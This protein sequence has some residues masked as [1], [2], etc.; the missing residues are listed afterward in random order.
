MSLGSTNKIISSYH[1]RWST[2]KARIVR[3]EQRGGAAGGRGNGTIGSRLAGEVVKQLVHNMIRE[4]FNGGG[5]GERF[6]DRNPFQ[7]FLKGII[8]SNSIGN[9]KTKFPTHL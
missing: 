5:W 8:P 6:G 4:C 1:G 9:R 2:I 3:A 7:G